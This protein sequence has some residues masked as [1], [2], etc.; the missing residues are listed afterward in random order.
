M[1]KRHSHFRTREERGTRREAYT[2]DE[3][4]PQSTMMEM[5]YT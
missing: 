4:G 3:V 1:N 5:K 2:G